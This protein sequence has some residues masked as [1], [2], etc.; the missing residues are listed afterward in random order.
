[1]KAEIIRPGQ[2]IYKATIKSKPRVVVVVVK[3]KG[4]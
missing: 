1:M 2:F 3:G 4:K